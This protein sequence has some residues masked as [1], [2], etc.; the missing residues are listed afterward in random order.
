M[1]RR[2][3][4][5]IGL[6]IAAVVL[7]AVPAAFAAAPSGFPFRPDPQ[8]VTA[9]PAPPASVTPPA[10][11][12]SVTPP[13]S[14]APAVV[15]VA[16]VAPGPIADLPEAPGPRPVHLDP[17]GPLDGSPAVGPHDGPDTRNEI[18]ARCV[19]SIS[20]T[21]KGSV[22]C[23]WTAREGLDVAGWQLWK[24]RVRPEHGDRLLV[25]EVRPEVTTFVDTDVAVPAHYTYAVLGINEAGEVIARSA[26]V[27]VE[28][29]DPPVHDRPLRLNCN[30]MIGIDRVDPAVTSSPSIGC[31]WS[32][33]DN[34]TAVGYVLW[35]MVDGGDRQAIAR[36][37]LDRL[38]YVDTEVTFAQRLTYVVTAVDANGE[39][40]ARSR[41]EHVGLPEPHPRP[42]PPVHILPDPSRGPVATAPPK[43]IG[44]V[45][46]P[47]PIPMDP[48]SIGTHQPGSAAPQSPSNSG[49]TVAP[50]A[51]SQPAMPRTN[52]SG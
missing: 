15:D 52:A 10:P 16:P 5:L 34:E 51:T 12:A 25:V 31:E 50:P 41:E 40:V 24:L 9:P 13:V 29:V 14:E 2:F 18:K 35:R 49:G 28:L 6:L 20:D 7:A 32:P 37:G 23:N 44:P 8:P 1:R 17:A 38:R 45:D 26:A 39:V 19:G 42:L 43:P 21:G 30:P 47:R 33:T 4:P 36:T 27:P 22:E 11:P 3:S 48:P 46:A